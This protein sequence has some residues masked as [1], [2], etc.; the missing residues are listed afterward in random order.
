MADIIMTEEE[1]FVQEITD[2]EI[3]AKKLQ[4]TTVKVTVINKAKGTGEILSA[5]LFLPLSFE[6]LADMVKVHGEAAVLKVALSG[7][8]NAAQNFFRTPLRKRDVEG[9]AEMSKL[10]TLSFENPTSMATADDIASMLSN[11]LVTNETLIAKMEEAFGIPLTAQ[12]KGNLIT[13]RA[14]LLAKK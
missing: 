10:W 14:G 9:L 8:K 2:E 4:E 11:P 5:T 13:K 12:Q 7:A 6:S 1:V 3:T